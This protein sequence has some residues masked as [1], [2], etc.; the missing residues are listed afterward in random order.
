MNE[1][2]P[3]K[4]VKDVL[5]ATYDKFV[6]RLPDIVLWAAGALLV[7]SFWFGYYSLAAI[8]RLDTIEA[9]Q[10]RSV[11]CQRIRDCPACE[12]VKDAERAIA[13]AMH[14]MEAHDKDAEQW[15][16]RT[17]ALEAW[18]YRKGIGP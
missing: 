2:K 9:N 8:T 15:K 3:R 10:S 4:S 5:N 16:K 6:E 7:A 14:H 18:V 1:Q 17:E 11:F 12:A 13:D